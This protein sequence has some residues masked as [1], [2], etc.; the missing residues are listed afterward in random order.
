MCKFDP[1]RDL[2]D[3]DLNDAIDYFVF[4]ETTKEKDDWDEDGEEGD[5]DL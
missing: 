4:D 5:D 3:D 1:L 2:L